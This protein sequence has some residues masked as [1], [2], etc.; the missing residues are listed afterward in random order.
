MSKLTAIECLTELQGYP[1][2]LDG[3]VWYLQNEKQEIVFGPYNSKAQAEM[4]ALFP[5][6]LK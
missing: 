2:Y 3:K 5:D 4:L 1:N 6:S